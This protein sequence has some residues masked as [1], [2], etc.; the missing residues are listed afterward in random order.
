[1]KEQKTDL[2]KAYGRL[3][4]LNLEMN[5]EQHIELSNILFDLAKDQ[6][7]KGVEVTSEIYNK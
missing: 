5:T 7:N 1:M 3:R 4:E 2:T 6:F